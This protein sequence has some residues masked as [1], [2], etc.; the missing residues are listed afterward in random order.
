MSDELVPDILVVNMLLVI[1][2]ANGIDLKIGYEEEVAPGGN[3][4]HYEGHS[5]SA[6]E[7]H[8]ASTAVEVWPTEIRSASCRARLPKLSAWKESRKTMHM[9]KM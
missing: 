4:L 8:S 3:L 7:R 1:D 5:E 6:H 2:F 9:D